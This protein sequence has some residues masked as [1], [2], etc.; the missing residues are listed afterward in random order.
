ML[1]RSEFVSAKYRQPDSYRLI[2]NNW[3][4]VFNINGREY[5]VQLVA[6][7]RNKNNV[8]EIEILCQG[9]EC[10][11]VLASGIPSIKQAMVRL[12]AIICD[13]GDGG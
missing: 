12:E 3:V 8:R 13:R 1:N 10:R 5:H 11:N 4:A 2:F 7:W 6:D 9:A